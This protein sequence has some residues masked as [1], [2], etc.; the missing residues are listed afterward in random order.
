MHIAESIGAI[1]MT[2]GVCK[3]LQLLTIMISVNAFFFLQL[4]KACDYYHML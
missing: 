4:I 2:S 3:P 1:R